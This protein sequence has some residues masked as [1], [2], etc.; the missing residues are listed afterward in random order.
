MTDATKLAIGRA[1]RRELAR[2]EQL[3]FTRYTFPG[4]RA[5]WFHE[6]YCIQLDRFQRG[7]VRKLIVEVPPQ[8]GKSE[9]CSRRMPAKILGNDP[10]NRIGL[11][12]YNQPFA[13]KFNR[14][15]QRIIDSAEYRELFPGTRLNNANVRTVVG[16]WLRNADEFEVVGRRGGLITVG[17][18]GGLTG[19]ALDTLI[20]DDPYKDAKEAWSPTVRQ[21]VQD[22]YDTVAQ[23]RLH[24]GSR[25]L[26]TM[27]RWHPNDLV[28]VLLKR[29]PGEW[30][31]V[32][33]PAI[34]I[35]EPTELD[36]RPD[37]A[38]LWEEQHSLERLLKIKK[39]NPHVFQ[40]LYQQDPRPAEGLLFPA[41]SLQYF[42]MKDIK[43]KTPDAVIAVADVADTGKDYYCLLIA[44]IYDMEIYVMD[45]VFTQA[46]AEI[47]EPLTVGAINNWRVQRAQFESNAGGRLY[48]KSIRE[49]LNNSYTSVEAVPSSTNKE[50]RILTAS[51]AVKQHVHFRSDAPPNSDYAKFL[52]QLTCHQLQGKNEHDDAADTVTMLI[53]AAEKSRITY[54]IDVF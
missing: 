41:D 25:Q 10:D 29:E 32:Q 44:H 18:G 27:T 21:S 46:Q 14:D 34:K 37:G 54:E 9:Q 31:V 50:T 49:K 12:T 47:T 24:N 6:S 39:S 4:Y 3:A 33:F 52:D 11:A 23:T 17:V 40:S 20:I 51:G 8:H 13:A 36:P 22:W 15:V 38:A 43:G 42:D 1:A 35:G 48:A 7:E 28:G 19:R 16:S 53:N 5:N 30:T 45:A 26:L 2:R